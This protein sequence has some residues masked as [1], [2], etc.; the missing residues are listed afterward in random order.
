M[1]TLSHEINEAVTDPQ[2]NGNT[3]W[4][5]NTGNEIGD[6]CSDI[7]GAPQGSTDTEDETYAQQSEFNQVING[8]DYWTQETF[9]NAT[10]AAFKIGQG[11]VQ[12]AFQPQGSAQPTQPAADLGSGVVSASQLDLPADGTSTSTITETVSKQDGEPAVADDVEFHVDTSD[13]ATGMCGTLSGG[14]SDAGKTPDFAIDAMT[15]E[16]GQASV[17]Y[18]SSTD[19]V[20]CDATA[21]EAK[22]GTTD[23]V[24]IHQGNEAEEEAA[25]ISAGNLPSSLTAGAAAVTFTTTASNP[26]SSDLNGKRFNALISP[27]MT[28]APAALTRARS[29]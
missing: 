21:T 9:S 5:D 15:D 16:N 18:T 28:K 1:S 8:H 3:G 23:A 12:K 7:F 13:G 10:F 19:D 4:Y 27:A 25:T 26:S 11:C 29:S 6:D 20:S 22:G 24:T 17:T 2:Y 14:S